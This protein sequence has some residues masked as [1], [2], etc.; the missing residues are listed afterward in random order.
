[1]KRERQQKILDIISAGRI[2]T[3]QQ[4]AD[5]LMRRGV[6]A[7]QSSVSRDIVEMGLV[8]DSGYYAAPQSALAAAGPVLALDTAGDNIIVVRTE[9]GQAQPTALAIDRADIP[10]I[11]GTV[12]GDDTIMIAV[13]NLAGQRVAVKKI[14]KLFTPTRALRDLKRRAAKHAS[15]VSWRQVRQ[16]TG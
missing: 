1:M 12:A 8:K 6:A 9:V 13:K 3:Q 11:V 7:T 15:G 4:L 2:S 14:V 10:E 16:R 5:A